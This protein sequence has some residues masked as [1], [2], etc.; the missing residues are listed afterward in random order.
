MCAVQKANFNFSRWRRKVW[1]EGGGGRVFCRKYMFLRSL[2]YYGVN[3]LD[4]SRK[5]VNTQ[6]WQYEETF[7]NVKQGYIAGYFV[8][9]SNHIGTLIALNLNFWD[10]IEKSFQSLISKCPFKVF[11]ILIQISWYPDIMISRYQDIKIS[12]YPDFAKTIFNK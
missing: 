11:T 10:P 9:V 12:R 2:K 3:F 5:K 1:G 6:D 7:N 4:I 8:R